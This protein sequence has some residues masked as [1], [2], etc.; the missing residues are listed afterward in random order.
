M[1]LQ[2][3]LLPPIFWFNLKIKKTALA[4]F[5]I[6]FFRKLATFEHVAKFLVKFIYATGCIYDFLGSGVERVAL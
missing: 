2:V 6:F 4:V 1:P 5:F 3:L